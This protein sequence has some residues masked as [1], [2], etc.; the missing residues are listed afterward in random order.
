MTSAGRKEFPRP[1]IPVGI[2][3]LPEAG[4][5]AYDDR[6]RGHTLYAV[7]D[8]RGLAA[9]MAVGGVTSQRK[10][11]EEM[12]RRNP[13]RL[14]APWALFIQAGVFIFD[15]PKTGHTIY[16]TRT[17]EDTD[18]CVVPGTPPGQPDRP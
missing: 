2:D 3:C 11:W 15:D 9:F 8:Q 14:I 5:W 6:V 10:S 13:W 1:R 16:I 17:R 4:L 12:Q 18:I 7:Q